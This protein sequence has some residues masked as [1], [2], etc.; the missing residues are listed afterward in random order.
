MLFK[1]TITVYEIQWNTQIKNAELLTFKAAGRYSYHSASKGEVV[2][3]E[4]AQ[5]D[6]FCI[7][8]S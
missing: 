2:R 3:L 1:E 5:W 8:N 6:M 4:Q 7:H